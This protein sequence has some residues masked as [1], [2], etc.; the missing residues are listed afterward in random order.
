M[1]IESKKTKIIT[2]FLI[3]MLL[4][5]TTFTVSADEPT[6]SRAVVYVD[7][8]AEASWYDA[9][10]VRTIQEGIDNATVGDTIFVYNGTYYEHV[11]VN[12]SLTLQGESKVN[13]IIDGQESGDVITLSANN[14]TVKSFTVKNAGEEQLSHSGILIDSNNNFIINNN[15]VNN[16]IYGINIIS[17]IGNS[18]KNNTIKNNGEGIRFYY[19]DANTLSE[20]TIQN[21]FYGIRNWYSSQN[22]ISN[23][24]ILSNNDYGIFHQT[25][26]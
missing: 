26:D 23:N 8:D 22:T 16:V 3:A 14:V 12:K 5:A 2:I 20:N 18:I 15:I 7:D 9:A 10:H 11:L 17:T 19:A 6:F 13:T 21:N 25:C 24:T 4:I 1:K